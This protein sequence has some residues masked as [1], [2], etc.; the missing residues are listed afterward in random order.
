MLRAGALCQSVDDL[1]DAA[2]AAAAAAHHLTCTATATCLS[3]DDPVDAAGAAAH[4]LTCTAIS[5]VQP[6]LCVCL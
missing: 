1:V 6:L 2:V 4:H 5:P 3:V